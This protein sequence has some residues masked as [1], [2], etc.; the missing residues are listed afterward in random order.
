MTV[1]DGKI[2]SRG[3]QTGAT[4]TWSLHDRQGTRVLAYQADDG[5]VTGEVTPAK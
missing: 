2:R 4:G 1:L 3:D 5:R